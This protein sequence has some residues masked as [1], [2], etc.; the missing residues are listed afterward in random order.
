MTEKV[1]LEASDAELAALQE[2]RR[3]LTAQLVRM[4]QENINTTT[5]CTP[6]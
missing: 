3:D 1:T 5:R 6:D 2:E 4:T